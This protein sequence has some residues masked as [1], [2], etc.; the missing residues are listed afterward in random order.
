MIQSK[1][2]KRNGYTGI[3]A[4]GTY[5]SHEDRSPEWK[6]CLPASIPTEASRQQY[7]GYSCDVIERRFIIKCR[8]VIYSCTETELLVY[9]QYFWINTT[10]SILRTCVF[11]YYR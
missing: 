6:P 9:K 7:T 3:I 8:T 4:T 5:M 10:G 1:F 2:Y 11:A